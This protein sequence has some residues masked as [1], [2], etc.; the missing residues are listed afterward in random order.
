MHVF[1]W[2]YLVFFMEFKLNKKAIYQEGRQEPID[3]VVFE[4]TNL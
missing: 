1:I 4:K 3:E 2:D